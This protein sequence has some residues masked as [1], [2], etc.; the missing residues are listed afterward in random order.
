MQPDQPAP[1]SLEH[2]MDQLLWRL[3]KL[4]GDIGQ[5][6][7]LLGAQRSEVAALRARSYGYASADSGN[8]A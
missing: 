5:L 1:L 7:I 4:E 3:A 6:R 2:R 8:L